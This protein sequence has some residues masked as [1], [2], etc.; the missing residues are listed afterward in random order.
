MARI[1]IVHV[2]VFC[3]TTFTFRLSA[4]CMISTQ[5]K[6][7]GW[8][9]REWCVWYGFHISGL[10]AFLFLVRSVA[11]WRLRIATL[12]IFPS[13]I[14]SLENS[15]QLI[16]NYSEVL[17]LWVLQLWISS[18]SESLPLCLGFAALCQ[19]QSKP[20]ASLAFD[21][22]IAQPGKLVLEP[23]VPDSMKHEIFQS[24]SIQICWS[25]QQFEVS[26]PWLAHRIGIIVLQFR[27]GDTKMQEWRQVVDSLSCEAHHTAH[28]RSYHPG[29]S[30]GLMQ[31]A[32]F[33][34]K[35]QEPREQ[36]SNFRPVICF[37]AWVH[38]TGWG[39]RSEAKTTFPE[40]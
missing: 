38:W 26:Q 21:I 27:H 24:F 20:N 29:A 25:V 1:K 35:P 37:R 14:V 10:H 12:W 28:L 6:P 23:Q 16:S 2:Q 17:T 36:S 18:R 19:N 30:H 4:V 40:T 11:F 13:S 7:A 31:P 8:Y 5:G 15:K 3:E 39:Y 34:P 32:G 22:S 33:Q 9:L